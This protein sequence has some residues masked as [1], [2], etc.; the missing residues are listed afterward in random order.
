MT[1]NILLATY[2]G[3]RF[4]QDQLKSIV[5]QS[6]TEWKLYISD[7]GSTDATNDII[8]N[9]KNHYRD[10][11]FVLK[12]TIPFKN[13]KDNFISLVYRTDGD[14]FLFCDQDDVWQE[15]KLYNMI[16]KYQS[17]PSDKKKQPVLMHSDLIVVDAELNIIAPSFM[18]FAN[19]SSFFSFPELYLV[20]NNVT[21]CTMLI[22]DVLRDL[23]VTCLDKCKSLQK[24]IIMHDWFFALIAA[25]FGEVYFVDT[26]DIFYRQH[27]SNV[28]GAKNARSI[29]LLIKS[30]FKFKENIISMEE[31]FRQSYV[32]LKMFE[33]LLSEND[34]SLLTNFSKLNEHC[35]MYRIM[36]IIK[37][38]LWKNG[39]YRKFAQILFI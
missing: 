35:K 22:N 39:I 33:N 18:K 31:A 7:D 26:K 14:L 32:F 12:N 5:N 15:N 29:K 10:K 34:V 8:K 30:F 1:V 16:N 36:F 28:V 27:G 13:A 25:Y 20:Q 38:K 23:F 9:F 19:I 37:N 2:N 3:E 24:D 21:G 4:L 11:I 17:L 6:Y